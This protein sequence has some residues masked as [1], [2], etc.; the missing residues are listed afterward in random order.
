MAGH[1]RRVA[2][3]TRPDVVV[4]NVATLAA[5]PAFPRGGADAFRAN[6]TGDSPGSAVFT[7]SGGVC[8]PGVHELLWPAGAAAARAQAGGL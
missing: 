2:A 3:R 8:L 5:L 4:H 6:G 1:A 7:V